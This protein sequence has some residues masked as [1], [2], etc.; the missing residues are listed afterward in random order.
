MKK[1]L[2]WLRNMK[3]VCINSKKSFKI[4]N[5]PN[6]ESELVAA[7]G[8]LE[9]TG[10]LEPCSEGFPFRVKELIAHLHTYTRSGW[11]IDWWGQ[12]LS[13]DDI[14]RG[15]SMANKFEI[16]KICGNENIDLL[17]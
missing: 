8:A 12:I 13:R 11:I 6:V 9:L 15:V 4:Y 5:V 17:Q 16:A 1:T 7:K 10:A 2:A 14:F 3:D